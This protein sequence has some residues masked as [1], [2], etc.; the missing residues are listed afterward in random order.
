MTALLSEANAQ[1]QQE[2]FSPDLD[3]EEW[4][5]MQ[6]P[7]SWEE[8]DTALAAFDGFVWFQKTIDIPE[9]YAGQAMT[10]HLGRIDDADIT[11]FNDEKVGQ[12][13]GNNNFR[14]YEVP[15]SVVKAGENTITV[16]VQD[17][18]GN[19]GLMGPVNQM[20][21]EL[22]GEQTGISLDGPWKYNATEPLPKVDMFPSEPAILYNAMINPLIPFM[23]KGVIWYQGESNASRAKQY[24]T[25]FP[26]MIEDWRNQ[27]GIGKFPFLFVQLANFITGGPGDDSWAELREAQLMALDLDNTGMAVTIDI[28]DSTDIHPRNK[29]DV[30][31]RL[32]IAALKVA[33]GQE[34][35]WSGPM[36][37][38]MRVEGDSVILTFSEVAEGL[39]V[40][41][42]EKLKGFTIAGADQQF[43]PATAKIISENEVSVKSPQVAEPEAVRYGWANN[44]KTNLYNEAFLPASPFRTDDWENL[45]NN[46]NEI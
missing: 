32:A 11:W 18:A 13:Y 28:G 8:A 14:T 9:R 20:Y 40:V 35:A 27:W 12:T 26:L 15:A 16:R 17:N 22:S 44:P 24:Q 33:Y 10:L 25:L 3:T 34:N 19:G 39:M 29:Q 45:Q 42:G 37:E 2:N 31:K 7:A 41:P 5:S 30:G 46:Q 23:L 36:Y 38:S 43:Y 4:P 21:M 6:L 1:M